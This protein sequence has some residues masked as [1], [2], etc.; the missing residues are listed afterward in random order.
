[1]TVAIPLE[2]DILVPFGKTA[3][4]SAIYTVIQKKIHCPGL[5]LCT[6]SRATTLIIS[7][8][9]MNGTIKFV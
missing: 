6:D 4:A 3:D 7:D 1:M 5:L 9:E 8:K 2:R